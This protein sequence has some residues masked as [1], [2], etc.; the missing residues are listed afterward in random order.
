MNYAFMPI[1]YVGLYAMV[2][3]KMT[4]FTRENLS[5]S[6]GSLIRRELLYSNITA[7]GEQGF[8]VKSNPTLFTS[9]FKMIGMG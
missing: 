1:C 3:L 5:H 8:A 4:N 9:L 6:L 2:P 7:P